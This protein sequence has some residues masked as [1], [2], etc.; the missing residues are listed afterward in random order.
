MDII[1]TAVVQFGARFVQECARGRGLPRYFRGC[2]ALFEKALF[3][4]KALLAG[5]FEDILASIVDVI[6]ICPK[7]NGPQKR[8]T[9][10]LRLGKSHSTRWNSCRCSVLKLIERLAYLIFFISYLVTSSGSTGGS[11]LD[12]S[13]YVML[14]IIL[15]KTLVYYC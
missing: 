5:K 9:V 14:C 13:S 6:L 1:T 2:K 8:L 3:E 15:N 7:V 11:E 12:I 4:K 10:D